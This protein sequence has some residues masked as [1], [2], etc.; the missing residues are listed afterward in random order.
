VAFASITEAHEAYIA[1]LDYDDEGDVA[2]ARLFRAA[3]RYL[4]MVRPNETWQGQDKL[5]IEPTALQQQ[6]DDVKAWLKAND[7]SST[8]AKRGSHVRYADLRGFRS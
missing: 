4:L 3:C 7:V 1:N 8:P 2:K 6:Y 5:R